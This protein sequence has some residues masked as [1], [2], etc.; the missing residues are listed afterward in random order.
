MPTLKD[1]ADLVG[2]SI[3]TASRVVRNDTSRHINPE[4]R[5]KVW[6]AVRQ[7][8]YTPN[9]SARH[10]VNKQKTEKR[11]TKQIGCII[12]AA[13]LNDDHPYYSP[14]ITA[15]TKKILESGYS[16]AFIHT[17]DELADD[18]LLHRCIHDIQV[19]GIIIVGEVGPAILDY[20]QKV[21]DLALIGI[22]TIGTEI[23][24]VDYDRIHAAKSAV[25]HLIAQGHRS[26]GFI[27]GPGHTGEL[28][29]EERFQGYKFAMY[30][31]GIPLHKDWV[32]DTR[33][34]IDRSY[35]Y[36][37]E[38]LKR[39]DVER[40]TAIFSA[41][42][43]LAIPAMRAVIESQLRIPEDMAFIS[44][45]NIDFAQYTTPPLSSVHVPKVEIGLTAAATLLDM[46]KGE[47]LALSKV[48][49]PHKIIVR[50]SSTFARN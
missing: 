32:I 11:Q 6:E 31:A 12:Q 4:T 35:E 38:Q 27:G 20:L 3:S 33:W 43:Q 13:R 25:D 41:S 45:D 7:L 22:C 19:D 2:V 18:A 39:T 16:L 49:L 28:N 23:T 10:L 8:D 26:I 44:M 50:E 36:V 14:I 24:M 30:D 40:P 21:E 1:I 34:E 9:E 5:A 42:D 48:L 37:K 47:Q 15:F 46:L 17:S 29:S